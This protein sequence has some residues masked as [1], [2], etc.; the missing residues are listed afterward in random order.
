MAASE[1]LKKELKSRPKEEDKQ[2]EDRAKRT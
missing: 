2:T 1:E